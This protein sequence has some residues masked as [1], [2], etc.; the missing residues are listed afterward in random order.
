[1][2]RDASLSQR[3]RLL[4]RAVE[5]GF[6]SETEVG[7]TL[8][9]G[10]ATLS[11]EAVA[12]VFDRLHAQGRIPAELL[13]GEALAPSRVP[14]PVVDFPM[15]AEGPYQPLAFLG[16]GG[17]GR[18]FKALDRQLGRVVALKFLKRLEPGAL[19]RFLTEGRAQ[20]QIEHPH[21]VPV[22]A[23]GDVEGQPY[24]AMRFIDG[25]SLKEALPLLSLEQKVR[26]V[27][28]CAEALHACHRLGILHRDVKPTNIMLERT[29]TGAW[30][31]FV[32]DF[33]LARELGS[34]SLTVT[35]VIVGTPVYCSPEQV[36][37]RLEAVDRRSDV[38]ALGATLYE[39]LTGHP[40]YSALGGLVELI[41]RI[42][43]EEPPPLRH[44]QPSLPRDLQTIVS[45]CMEKD[46]ARRYDSAR[47]LAEDLDRF[48]EGEPIHARPAGFWDRFGKRIR[49]NRLLTAVIVL[50]SALVV[51]LSALGITLA[52]RAQVQA[53]SAQRF[54]QEAER[55]ESLIFK[56]HSLPLH[57]IRPLRQMVEMRLGHL[58]QDL[59]RQ[60]RWSQAAGRLALGRGY[61]ALGRPETARPHLEA[62]WRL[63]PEPDAAHALG[64]ALA[65]IYQDEV[66][67]L[68]GPLRERRKA[69]VGQEL[70]DPALELLKRAR[71]LP[72]ESAAY[73]EGMIALVED[74]PNEAQRRAREAQ[75][76]LPW[77]HEAWILEAEA[78]RVEASLALGRGD[79]AAAQ[80]ALDAGGA[81]L[82]QALEIA[83]SAP[84]VR[85][86]EVQRRMLQFQ[87]R[88]D[89]GRASLEDHAAVLAAVD[90][91]LKTDPEHPKILGFASAAHR[92][93]GARQMERGED[94]QASLDAAIHR[95]RQGLQQ[96]PRDNALLN[97]F[98]TALRYRATWAMRQGRDPRPDLAQAQHA[99]QQALERP[100]FRDFLLNNLG[101]CYELQ[102]EWEEAHGSD[103]TAAARKAV[104][105]FEQA[106]AIRPWVGHRSSQGMTLATLARWERRQ[107]RDPQPTLALALQAFDQALA[108]NPASFQAHLAKAS[109]LLDRAD[110]LKAQQRPME[111]DLAAA[112]IHLERA[113][114]LSPQAGAE[115][116]R[117]RARLQRMRSGQG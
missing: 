85:L 106:S 49:R 22:H 59:A 77:F 52:L 70:R 24:L 102:A 35:G 64:L 107:G 79:H 19:E 38:Y 83:R 50:G 94:P 55:L 44:H 72:L 90:Q 103:P 15:P 18:V 10:S 11:E 4:R 29:E 84:S 57:D 28:Q 63:A 46:P 71:N 12:A 117:L 75:A 78:L 95:A 48:L 87:L 36:Q 112:S 54:G 76:Q 41:R 30:W 16:D 105:C 58:E 39:C 42:C 9:P 98:G 20:A 60:G 33:G 14:P 109:A 3:I 47:A 25:P 7:L 56:A 31:P 68:H 1:M 110:H 40:P 69:E 66:E 34:D 108:L 96:A 81:V 100:R 99:L 97:N 80:A 116:A 111:P 5:L 21:V 92:R 91:A 113:A 23:V 82:V 104:D 62:A 32:M 13:A 2:S 65:R 6:V 114:T 88:T 37:G 17:M 93:W 45:T 26:I 74:R 51:G 61:L 115:A 73:V 101:C 67:G 53:Q 86:A 8:D 27:Q 89:Q 43:E